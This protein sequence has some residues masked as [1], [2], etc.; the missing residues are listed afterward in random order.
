MHTDIHSLYMLYLKSVI[1]LAIFRYLQD[2][3]AL[4]FNVVMCVFFHLMFVFLD[5]MT[6]QKFPFLCKGL[7][8]F[9][10]LHL[11]LISVYGVRQVFSLTVS[12]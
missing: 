7:Q 5:F 3:G 8:Y 1:C 6:Y 11:E 10:G 12:L 2:M 4:Y 9:H